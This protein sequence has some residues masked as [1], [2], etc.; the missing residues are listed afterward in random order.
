M[1]LSTKFDDQDSSVVDKVLHCPEQMH[2]LCNSLSQ[3]SSRHCAKT[4]DF[5]ALDRINVAVHGM[6]GDFARAIDELRRRD[7]IDEEKAAAIIAGHNLLV[8]GIAAFVSPYSADV[9]LVLVPPVDGFSR[10]SVLAC[11]MLRYM[12]GVCDQLV[13]FDTAAAYNQF[14]FDGCFDTDEGND[15]TGRSLAEF[16]DISQECQQQQDVDLHA[17]ESGP[18]IV[19]APG[20][21]SNTVVASQLFGTHSVTVN[22]AERGGIVLVD[23]HALINRDVEAYDTLKSRDQRELADKFTH[24]LS[25][26]DVKIDF[27][28]HDEDALNVQASLYSHHR[29]VV[30]SVG[31]R[32]QKFRLLKCLGTTAARYKSTWEDFYAVSREGNAALEGNNDDLKQGLKNVADSTSSEMN[33]NA[34]VR[35]FFLNFTFASHPS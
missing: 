17:R 22:G 13:A 21:S 35:L 4:I 28:R 6:Y 30:R 11:Q 5:D 16:F 18:V 2:R 29:P 15:G 10:K 19:R 33:L 1:L 24:L 3:G 9:Y 20:R 23:Q 14:D 27:K 34:K 31:V 32:E 8:P 25:V 26:F 12:M 7:V